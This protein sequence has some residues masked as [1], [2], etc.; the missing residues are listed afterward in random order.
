MPPAITMYTESLPGAGGRTYPIV[1]TGA[2]GSVINMEAV[3]VPGYD[4]TQWSGNCPISN[5]YERVTTVLLTPDSGTAC[6][7]TANMPPGNTTCGASWKPCCA[8]NACNAGLTC[9]ATAMCVP[10]AGTV[11]MPDLVVMELDVPAYVRVGM[12]ASGNVRITNV[13]NAPAPSSTM[14]YYL[15]NVLVN[16]VATPG[17][18]PS[19]GTTISTAITCQ[20]AGILTFRARADSGNAVVE[21]NETN[22]EQSYT[23]LCLN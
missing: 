16:N 15:N 23:I 8:G 6:Y 3:P 11:L 21:R 18:A 20:S 7:F 5:V 19:S 1:S 10:S 4:F 9:N 2:Y 13:G 12:P 14:S 22:N 17:L